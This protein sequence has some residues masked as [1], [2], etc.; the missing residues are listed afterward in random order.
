MKHIYIFL[1]MISGLLLKS[2]ENISS[3]TFIQ[4][5][6][7]NHQCYSINNSSYLF[8]DETKSSFY[9]RVDFSKFEIGVDSI[10]DWLKDLEETNLIFKAPMD[11]AQ[12]NGLS[13]HRHKDLKLNG[14][15]FFN[16]IWKDQT[17]DLSLYLSENGL[18]N[19]TNSQLNYD[20]YKVN[21]ILNV[22]PKDF[23][24]HKKPHHLKKSIVIGV[25]LGRINKLM[26]EM[27]PSLGEAYNH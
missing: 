10:D 17:I 27:I 5:C 18:L 3:S 9:L 20:R 16:G 22:L 6:I 14:Q 19:I 21:F 24:I 4:T 11:A 26:P 23:K 1:L 15:I 8:Y 13:N 2:Q 7:K 25:T 12:F